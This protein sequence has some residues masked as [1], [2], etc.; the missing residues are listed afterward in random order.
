MCG[1]TDIGTG[2]GVGT[3]GFQ[4]YGVDLRMQVLIGLILTMTTTPMDGPTTKGTGTMKIT[5]ITTIGDAASRLLERPGLD[6]WA[7]TV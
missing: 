3:C 2:T 1:S 4:E 6:G 5:V 7:F